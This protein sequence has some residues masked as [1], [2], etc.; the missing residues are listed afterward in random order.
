MTEHFAERWAAK[1][2]IL[3]SLGSE[4][5]QALAWND[6]EVRLLPDGSARVFACGQAK[7]RVQELRV[8]DIMVTMAHCRAYAT[9]TAIALTGP[10]VV[11]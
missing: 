10:E 8:S 11:P 3:K 1:E 2:A 6:L 4:R 9:A 5:R 7:E